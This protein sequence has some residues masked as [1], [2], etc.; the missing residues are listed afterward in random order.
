MGDVS[1]VE[2]G[3]QHLVGT[4]SVTNAIT[5]GPTFDDAFAG[6]FQSAYRIA[7]R[8]L[9]DREDAA[10]VAQEALARASGRW[11]RLAAA[12]D[13]TP[14]VVRVSANLALDRWRRRKTAAKYARMVTPVEGQS[15]MPD[16][17]DLHRA[18]AALPKRQREVVVLRYVADLPEDAVA[19][20]LRCAVGTVKTHASRG[21]AALRIAL[22]EEES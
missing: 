20:A 16:R 1:G 11:K 10:D 13:P 6:L 18:L 12:G 2:E 17:V 4:A 8:L 3:V 19:T 15:E 14:W 9:G 7:F 22:S 5:T 21:L